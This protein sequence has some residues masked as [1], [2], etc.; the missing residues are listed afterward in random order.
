MSLRIRQP[1]IIQYLRDGAAKELRAQ[2]A[3]DPEKYEELAAAN[4]PPSLEEWADR[5]FPG[6]I[7]NFGLSFLHELVD[8]PRIGSLF[9]QMKWW[10]WNFAGE[11]NDLLVGDHPLI[12]NSGIEDPNF[13]A[14]LPIGPARA[15][16]ATR[17]EAVATLLRSEKPRHLIARINE[18]T[19]RQTTTRI[20]ARNNLPRRFI[21]SRRR[22]PT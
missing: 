8:N 1:N 11:R 15:F 7:E 3:A 2:I 16:M 21:A 22:W 14:V 6:L 9:M 5:Q 4:D 12:F 18:A 20:Y 19:I 13:M 10:L 17:S